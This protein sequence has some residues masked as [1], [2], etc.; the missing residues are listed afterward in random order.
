[1]TIY[2]IIAHLRKKIFGDQ[3]GGVFLI[4]TISKWNVLQKPSVLSEKVLILNCHVTLILWTRKLAICSGHMYLTAW[5][6]QIQPHERERKREKGEEKN[7]QF[8]L[9]YFNFQFHGLYTFFPVP[10]CVQWLT[11]TQKWLTFHHKHRDTAGGHILYILLLNCSFVSFSPSFVQPQ[12]AQHT[13]AAQKISFI[14]VSSQVI[15]KSLCTGST[16]TEEPH[17][18]L[19]LHPPF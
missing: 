14:R 9:P 15:V 17:M 2:Y 13:K 1:M 6:L 7:P 10:L 16:Q 11:M 19:C 8:T 12:A 5:M 4:W 3:N 18:L